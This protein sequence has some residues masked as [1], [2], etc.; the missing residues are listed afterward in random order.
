MLC[1]WPV[2]RYAGPQ[3]PCAAGRAGGRSAG[4]PGSARKRPGPPRVPGAPRARIA[5][6][7]PCARYA[8]GSAPGA[9]G[10]VRRRWPRRQ[11]AAGGGRSGLG[12][13]ARPRRLDRPLDQARG[14]RARAPTTR[15]SVR[16]LGPPARSRGGAGRRAAGARPGGAGRPG[17]STAWPLLVD[18]RRGECSTTTR[19]A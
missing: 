19:R 7:R 4:G 14:H 10:A 15:W 13:R 8:A 17:S 5:G 6:G 1:G 11:W 18:R 3:P 12:A 16:R 9:P 2:G